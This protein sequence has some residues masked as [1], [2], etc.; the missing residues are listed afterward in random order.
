MCDEIEF[1]SLLLHMGIPVHALCFLSHHSDTLTLLSP[2]SMPAPCAKKLRSHQPIAGWSSAC[3]APDEAESRCILWNATCWQT[4]VLNSSICP[5]PISSPRS[6][7]PP[8]LLRGRETEEKFKGSLSQLFFSLLWRCSVTEVLPCSASRQCY[9]IGEGA[10]QLRS[11]KAVCRVAEI[12]LFVHCENWRPETDGSSLRESLESLHVSLGSQTSALLAFLWNRLFP[13]Q[14]MGSRLQ[15]S[16]N[17]L[18]ILRICS[19][20][21]HG[22]HSSKMSSLY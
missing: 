21:Q 22:S 1:F 20:W 17:M 7:D 6:E 18:L 4:T 15:R 3:K 8:P 14:K 2:S 11:S 13:S 16:W 10:K 5:H 19:E 12:M 9:S